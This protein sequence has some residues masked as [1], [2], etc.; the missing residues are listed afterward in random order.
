[1]LFRH[2]YSSADPGAALARLPDWRELPDAVHHVFRDAEIAAPA[3]PPVESGVLIAATPRWTLGSRR[4]A[5]R[6]A[7]DTS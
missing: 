4:R 6:W 2:T 1:M 3:S 7:R 5:A